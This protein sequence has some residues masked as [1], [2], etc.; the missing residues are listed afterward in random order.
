[1][2]LV[3]CYRKD[4]DVTDSDRKSRVVAALGGRII[5]VMLS[6]REHVK[7]TGQDRMLIKGIRGR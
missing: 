1:M 3:M 5:L 7:G 2:T 6:S 4:G